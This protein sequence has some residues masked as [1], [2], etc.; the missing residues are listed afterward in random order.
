MQKPRI[1]VDTRG[2]PRSRVIEEKVVE[3]KEVRVYNRK[4]RGSSGSVSEVAYSGNK[5]RESKEQA[6]SQVKLSTRVSNLDGTI[7]DSAH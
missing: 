5:L 1:L 2:F 4:E 3:E 6:H 7:A